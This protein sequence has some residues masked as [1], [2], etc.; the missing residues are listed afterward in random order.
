MIAIFQFSIALVVGILAF[1]VGTFADFSDYVVWMY[2]DPNAGSA[3]FSQ[4]L[5]GTID[6]YYKKNIFLHKT[7]LDIIEQMTS[8][9]KAGQLLM[10]AWE[11]NTSLDAFITQTQSLHVGGMMVLRNDVT[12]GQVQTIRA[13]LTNSIGEMNIAPLMA[14]D[15]EPSLLQ[16]RI[17]VAGY[18]TETIDLDTT[19]KAYNAGS[20]IGELL[21]QYGYNYNFAP[22]YD[23]GVN[24]TV[25]G[26]RAFSQNSAEI[27][28]RAQAFTDGLESQNI[29][30]T[31]KHFPGHGMVVG[32]THNTLETVPGGLP[33]LDV[34]N[35]SI[36][37]R[38][39]SMMVGHLAVGEGQFDTSGVPATLSE[40]IMTNLLREQMNFTGVV[41][42]DAM[43]MGALDK[44]S[45]QDVQA[46]K[47]GADIILMPRNLEQAHK[48]IMRLMQTDSEFNR[49]VH[50]KLYRI[51]R[52]KLVAQWAET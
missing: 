7:T 49:A 30:A 41:I 13:A 25:I 34:F 52:L 43:V 4:S 26:N 35:A 21:S 24:R 1:I 14:I 2:E 10:P 3:V 15:A 8:E 37:S 20:E 45:D 42:T 5:K 32:D 36:Q 48:D 44:F 47:A 9:Q 23:S 40:G 31:A 27:I 28:E 6:D 46:I 29:I 22:V 51:I 17:P 12:V 38:I 19:E 39:P 16:Y 33:E 18:S 50:E 11:K